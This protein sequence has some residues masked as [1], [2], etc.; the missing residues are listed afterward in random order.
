MSTM[1]SIFVRFHGKHGDKHKFSLLLRKQANK[2][3]NGPVEPFCFLNWCMAKK[4]RKK[5]DVDL[6]KCSIFLL[7][8]RRLV[9][10]IAQNNNNNIKYQ[11]GRQADSR[12]HE[13]ERERERKKHH[14]RWPM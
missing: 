6:K 2:Q 13:R 3:L 10:N 4:K 8:L 11:T 12:Q 9:C 14:S 7:L 1:E 5:S